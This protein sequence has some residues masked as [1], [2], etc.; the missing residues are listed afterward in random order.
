MLKL[1]KFEYFLQKLS[2]RFHFTCIKVN[3]SCKK[4][5]NSNCFQIQYEKDLSVL[6][7]C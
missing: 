4:R 1:K 6:L 5:I 2:K 7:N 3:I